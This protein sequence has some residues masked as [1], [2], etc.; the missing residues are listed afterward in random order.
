MAKF[1]GYKDPILSFG[2]DPEDL[3]KSWAYN[4]QSGNFRFITDALW[5]ISDNNMELKEIF[6]AKKDPK[7]QKNIIGKQKRKKCKSS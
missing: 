6:D 5:Y 7:M 4:F 3:T 2:K 1:V